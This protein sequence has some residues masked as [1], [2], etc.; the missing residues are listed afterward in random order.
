MDVTAKWKLVF[1]IVLKLTFML[2][3]LDL[4]IFSFGTH[5]K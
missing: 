5:C 4:F 1:D 2:K 3:A